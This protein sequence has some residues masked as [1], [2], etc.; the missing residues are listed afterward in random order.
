VSTATL[1]GIRATHV[2]LSLPDWGVGWADASLDGE[3]TLSGAVELK[4]ADL[5]AQ[6]TVVSGG[7]AKG[8]SY[9]RVALGKAGWGN[10]I[11]AKSYTNDAGVKASTVLHDAAAAAGE[12][13]DA[14][15]LPTTRLGPAY[16]REAGP[17]SRALERIAPRGWY[18]GEDG[19]TRIGRRPRADIA[20]PAQLGVAD[21]SRGTIT[22]AAESIATVLP[23]VRVGG[24]EAV[25]VIHEV[26]PEG[27]RTT[28][29]GNA[30]TSR[31]REWFRRMLLA[32]VPDLLFRGI[33]EYRV[34]TQE[35]E[36]LNLQPIRASLGLPD[37]RRVFVRPGVAG[38]RADVA[39]GSRVI[40]GFVNADPAQPAVLA[41][42]D[43]EGEGFDPTRLDLAGGFARVLRD[44]ERVTVLGPATLANGI[45]DGIITIQPAV[46]TEGAPPL[47]KSKVRA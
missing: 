18:V 2:R 13:L 42:E 41:F 44:G 17:A 3:Q 12:T 22:L 6:C 10:S 35:G 36:R 11:A 15:T 30:P 4:V 37:L 16:T 33:Y 39:L 26:S 28:I 31:R 27:L 9:Y 24:I 23:G 47:G 20:V 1:A 32:S 19:T 46:L 25:D 45:A 7:P 21:L 29:Y 5:A 38:V 43:A 14:S 8:R 40:V 34:V